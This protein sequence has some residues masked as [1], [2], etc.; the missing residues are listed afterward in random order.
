MK[1]LLFLLAVFFVFVSAYAGLVHMFLNSS[2]R[3]QEFRDN[4]RASRCE[5]MSEKGLELMK[6]YCNE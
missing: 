5:R 6:G 4:L 2:E 1:H 3:E